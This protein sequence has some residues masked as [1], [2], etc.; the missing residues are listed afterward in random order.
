MRLRK[1]ASAQGIRVVSIEKKGPARRGGL[2]TGDIIVALAGRPVEG[3]D[4]LRRLLTE[5]QI[6]Q[7]CSLDV[8]RKVS[9]WHDDAGPCLTIPR[10]VVATRLTLVPV[11][12]P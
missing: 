7:T 5:D 4:A 1:L 11:E 3:V 6:G 2:R 9:L 12:A 8:L 10:Q